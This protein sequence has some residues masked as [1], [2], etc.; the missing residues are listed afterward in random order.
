MWRTFSDRQSSLAELGHELFGKNRGSNVQEPRGAA[1]LAQ[2]DRRG[3][4]DRR[5]S[6]HPSRAGYVSEGIAASSARR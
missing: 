4:W 5:S 3:P 6:D 2:D 1:A